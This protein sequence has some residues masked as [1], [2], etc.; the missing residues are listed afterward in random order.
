MR[1]YL[2]GAPGS[3]FLSSPGTRPAFAG[4]PAKS[5]RL[6]VADD[7]MN[8]MLASLWG[9][10]IMDRSFDVAGQGGSVAALQ[11]L[12]DRVELAMRLPPVVTALPNGGG[13]RITVGDVECLFIRARPGEPVKTVTRLSLSVEAT[14]SASVADNHLALVAGE[15][16]V[17]LDVL[18]DGVSGSNPLNQ[19]VVKQLA[20]FAAKNLVG[21]VSDAAAKVPI[22]AVEG[23]TIVDAQVSTGEASGGYLVVSGNVAV[24]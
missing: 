1:L 18:T 14:V 21:L 10:G 2:Q 23:M 3:V 4:G 7:A 5:I 6:G 8:Q 24:R 9:A 20:S 19:E 12:F 22:P 13:L 17:Y 11:S 16:T 15:P